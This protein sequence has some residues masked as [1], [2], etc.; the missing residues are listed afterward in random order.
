[1]AFCKWIDFFKLRSISFV[2]ILDYNFFLFEDFEI[3][4]AFVESTPGKLLDPG[5]V[6]YPTLVKIFFCNL[7]FITLDGFP[8]FK[9][10]C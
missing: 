6:S 10:L 3:N 2:D 5:S 8:S 4:F 7:S 9:K 1:M